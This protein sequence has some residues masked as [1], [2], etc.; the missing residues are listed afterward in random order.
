MSWTENWIR[1]VSEEFKS[2]EGISG[3]CTQGSQ[4]LHN[5][6]SG[7]PDCG[8]GLGWG[9]GDS[10]LPP[11]T[12]PKDNVISS[13]RVFDTQEILPG[14]GG[15]IYVLGEQ[16]NGHFE[17]NYIDSFGGNLYRDD[18]SA[19]WTIS[20]NVTQPR[21][22]PSAEHNNKWLYVW[23]PRCHDLNITTITPRPRQKRRTWALVPLT[24]IPTGNFPSR[25]K[26][27]PSSILPGL[28]RPIK[29]SWGNKLLRLLVS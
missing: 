2:E 16:H 17:D 10:G 26:R 4:I 25:H 1:D 19:F 14:D 21:K 28:S 29:T 20:N 9:W 5:D 15:A 12:V 6:I 3:F 8:I 18:G 22:G 24:P 27:K 7:V 11:S 13:N 23:T